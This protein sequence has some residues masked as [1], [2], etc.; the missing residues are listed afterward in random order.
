MQNLQKKV[1]EAQQEYRTEG[2]LLMDY[3][4]PIFRL[5][6]DGSTKVELN[7]DE[8]MKTINIVVNSGR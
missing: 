3:L 8:L 4:D 1:L 5:L 6:R 7:E 2:Y